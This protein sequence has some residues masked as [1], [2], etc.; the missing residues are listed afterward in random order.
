MRLMRGRG[1][2]AYT[3]QDAQTGDA[4]GNAMDVAGYT[5]LSVQV[6]GTFSGSVLF[7]ASVDGSN[8]ESVALADLGSATRART[9]EA[10]AAGLYL[11]ED[12]G[13]SQKFRARTANMASGTVDV[14]GI[15]TVA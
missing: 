8:W 9:T 10:T 3:F 13:V 11:F 14:K 12:A 5:S 1:T 2:A 4:N 15:A 7:E 6:I